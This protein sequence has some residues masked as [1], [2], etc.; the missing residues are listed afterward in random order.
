MFK[1]KINIKLAFVE[2]AQVQVQA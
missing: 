2:Y 1:V